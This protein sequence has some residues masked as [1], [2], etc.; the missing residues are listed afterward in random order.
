MWLEYPSADTSCAADLL[1]LKPDV[2]YYSIRIGLTLGGLSS[3]GDEH[4]SL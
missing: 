1:T 3:S 4:I 2:Y